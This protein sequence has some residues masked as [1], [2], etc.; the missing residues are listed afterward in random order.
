[1]SVQHCAP[2]FQG[3]GKYLAK[4][5]S[6]DT[7]TTKGRP[8]WRR[9]SCITSANY[10]LD[11]LVRGSQFFRH[12]VRNEGDEVLGCLGDEQE[13]EGLREKESV[14]VKDGMSV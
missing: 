11:N 12:V 7:F 8:D 5:Y 2:I 9:R 14:Q 10:Q 3:R 13:N 4:V 6:F 1:M